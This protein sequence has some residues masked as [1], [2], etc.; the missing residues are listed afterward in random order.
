MIATMQLPKTTLPNVLQPESRISEFDGY[1]ELAAEILGGAIEDWM[2]PFRSPHSKNDFM[3][4]RPDILDFLYSDHS[5]EKDT[6]TLQV[7]FF[8]GSSIYC[9]SYSVASNCEIFFSEL[10]RYFFSF[11]S[12]YIFSKANAAPACWF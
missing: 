6:N 3:P 12:K 1:K 2:D 7:F 4:S 9:F 11:V 8:I 5:G 10:T